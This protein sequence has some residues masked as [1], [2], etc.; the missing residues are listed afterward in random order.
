MAPG[1][2]ICLG[3][4]RQLGIMFSTAWLWD[5]EPQR[6]SCLPE[7]DLLQVDGR[8][9]ARDYVQEVD[10]ELMVIQFPHSVWSPVRQ[11]NQNRLS[12]AR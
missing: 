2:W 6:P 4:R 10:P 7:F 11:T 8:R 12:Q 5:G 3:E 9:Q 1:P